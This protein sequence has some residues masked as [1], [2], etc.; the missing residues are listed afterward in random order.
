LGDLLEEKNVRRGV[1]TSYGRDRKI[2]KAKGKGMDELK[3]Q[4]V[5]PEG[6][7]KKRDDI[8]LK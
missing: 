8:Q 7:K 2:G 3:T 4:A 1:K 6:W 5:V